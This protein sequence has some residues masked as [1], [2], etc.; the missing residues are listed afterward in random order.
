MD[1]LIVTPEGKDNKTLIRNIS[2]VCQQL[3]VPTE[4]LANY[5]KI[6]LST[7]MDIENN[8]VRLNG[9][10][11]DK[12]LQKHVDQFI[13]KYVICPKC[14]IPELTYKYDFERKKQKVNC[15]CRACAYNFE[16]QFD[17]TK[18]KKCIMDYPP[19]ILHETQKKKEDDPEK[20]QKK[21][22]KQKININVTEQNYLIGSSELN[23]IVDH[24]RTKWNES[25]DNKLI[26]ID[27][28]IDIY[29]TSLSKNEFLKAYVLWFS[30]IDVEN[31]ENTFEY[32]GYI[33]KD[34][35]MKQKNISRFQ[36]YLLI[37]IC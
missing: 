26:F 16:L 7:N 23:E 27:F 31:L 4:W 10:L 29:G 25:K 24:L 32:K 15:V 1:A 2:T 18:M 12:D 37:S 36:T 21:K 33:I 30:I 17:D 8:I 20:I 6:K 34:I 9:Q 28:I 11:S 3:H 5:F 13:K 35:L 14:E 22:E 19:K